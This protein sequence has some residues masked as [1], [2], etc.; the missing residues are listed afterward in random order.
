MEQA[1][2]DVKNMTLTFNFEG[3]DEV[4]KLPTDM[5][6]DHW[7]TFDRCG[8]F[9]DYNIWFD[10]FDGVGEYSF[11]LGVYETVEDGNGYLTIGDC[12]QSYSVSC[13]NFEGDLGEVVFGYVVDTQGVDYIKQNINRMKLVID[14]ESVNIYIDNGETKEPTHVCY[15]HLDEVEEDAN[16]A[17][18]IANAIDLFHTNKMKLVET[19][20]GIVK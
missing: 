18:S 6:S 4:V 11:Q 5:E 14:G 13:I 10:E 16:V 3:T 17:I 19:L 2:F 15:W 7:G 12:V 9:F 20:F 1:V 8:E